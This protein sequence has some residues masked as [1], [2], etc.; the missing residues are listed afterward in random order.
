MPDLR[1]ATS[2]NQRPDKQTRDQKRKSKSRLSGITFIGPCNDDEEK[3]I[4]CGTTVDGIS[5][6]EAVYIGH[7]TRETGAEP[8]VLSLDDMRRPTGNERMTSGNPGERGI[9]ES[10]RSEAGGSEDS[11]LED[12]A[13]AKLK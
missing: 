12:P 10:N 7:Q 3:R 4:S 1:F 13:S 2:N 6:P 11:G 8:G 5:S 9:R